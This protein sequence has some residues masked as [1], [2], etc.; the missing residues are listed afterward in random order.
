MPLPLLAIG[1]AAA[2]AAGLG[3]GVYGLVHKTEAEKRNR[4]QLEKLLELERGGRLGMSGAEQRLLYQQQH[5]PVRNYARQQRER[6][7]RYAAATGDQSGSELARLR[8]EQGRMVGQGATTAALN[9]AGAD[10]ARRQ[11]QRQEIEGRT[12][13][14]TQFKQD[15]VGAFFGGLTQAGAA[16]GELAG[17]P[18]GMLSPLTQNMGP[19]MRQLQKENP[20][21]YKELMRRALAAITSRATTTT[22]T[23]P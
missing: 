21:E 12:Q 8:Q 14:A 6:Y 5:D 10:E 15:R 16:V 19:Y 18:A 22:G 11:A 1:A 23:T 2:G 3:Q 4:A 17:S 7:E 9:V 20:D 13:A